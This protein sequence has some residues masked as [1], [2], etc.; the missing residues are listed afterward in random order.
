MR[1]I[2]YSKCLNASECRNSFL[3][4]D[5][6]HRLADLHTDGAVA[7]RHEGFELDRFDGAVVLVEA[8]RS[9]TMRFDIGFGDEG[10]DR[11]EIDE[12]DSAGAIITAVMSS[13][14]REVTP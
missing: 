3:D 7:A 10:V 8:A 9:Q 1:G 11:A 6:S 2:E 12:P 4:L 13:R 5:A 14:N